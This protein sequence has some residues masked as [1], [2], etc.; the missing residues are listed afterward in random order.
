[1][2]DD[3][4][5][6]FR[7]D[8]HIGVSYQ[9]V[10]ENELMGQSE[11]PRQS[12]LFGVL[13]ELDK[14]IIY[15]LNELKVSDPK[16]ATLLDAFDRKLNALINQMEI[17]NYLVQ[18]LAHKVRQVNISACGMG[19]QVEESLREDD[20]LLV[21]LVLIPGNVNITSYARVI[22]SEA[23]SEDE[24]YIRMDFFGMANQDQELLIQHIVRRQGHLIRA[25]WTE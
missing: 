1:M 18:R 10:E 21:D 11:P 17:D 25:N 16:L 15:E 19:L 24:Y 20:I 22:S 4:R 2:T 3:R 5:R 14:T 13:N 12:D 6:F 9:V 23:V 7:I 8:D